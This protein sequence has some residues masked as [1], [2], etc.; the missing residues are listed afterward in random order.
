MN[1][2]I[3]S[4]QVGMMT[5]LT[6]CGLYLGLSNVVLI[7]KSG[8][9][10]LV[11]MLLG[12]IIGLIPVLMC[13]KISGT[14]PELNIYE[15]NKKIFGKVLG[16][17]INGLLLL[18]YVA[19]LVF[20][21]RSII[22]FLTSKYFMNTPFYLIGCLIIITI[23]II[24]FKGLETIARISQVTFF[25]S[26][27]LVIFIEFFVLQ[28]VEIGNILP[29]FINNDYVSNILS[30]S[31]YYASSCA[32]LTML[33]LTINKSRIRDPKNYNKSIILFYLLGSLSLTLVMFY[34][35]S[36]FGYKL[37]SLFRYPEYIMLKKISISDANLHIENL[38]AFR[39]IFYM[40][41][42]ANVSLYGIMTGI[43]SFSNKIKLNKIIVIII[44]VLALPIAKMT[45]GNI[46]HSI[47][48]V[49]IFYLPYIAIPMITVLIVM[50]IGC[51]MI[52]KE[53][54]KK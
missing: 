30:G 53:P 14:H 43:K 4:I 41:A 11:A 45:F 22:I 23:L 3:S 9:E 29:M 2:K 52:K 51:L 48:T 5:A 8:S 25:A 24:C 10:V 32:L 20:A 35:V 39:W 21:L 44:V 38:L 47:I 49:K 15:K 50:F 18:I 1:G 19:M 34:V 31:I 28:Y 26:L 16:N 12:V 33:L 37:T 13:L 17:I 7:R 42:L 54:T 46:P 27:F 40:L 6:C 36:S